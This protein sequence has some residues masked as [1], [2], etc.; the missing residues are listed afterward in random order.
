MKGI[1]IFL[2]LLFSLS[3]VELKHYLAQ[4]AG[5]GKNSKDPTIGKRTCVIVVGENVCLLG[6]PSIMILKSLMMVNIYLLTY[7][8][9]CMPGTQSLCSFYQ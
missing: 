6:I 2:L 9:S 4:L 3:E 5:Q 7:L 8:D 1:A